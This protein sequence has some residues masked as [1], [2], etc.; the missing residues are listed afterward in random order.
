VISSR[1]FVQAHFK[2][3]KSKTMFIPTIANSIAHAVTEII[4]ESQERNML[5]NKMR[6]EIQRIRQ[7]RELSNDTHAKDMK[8]SRQ[9]LVEIQEKMEQVRSKECPVHRYASLLK[10][11]MIPNYILIL[12]AQV[13]RQVH[14][15]CVDVAQLRLAE[16]TLG[17][18]KKLSRKQQE[19]QLERV[20]WVIEA[21]V[22][23]L[24][25][26]VDINEEQ[27]K[28]EMKKKK[29]KSANESSPGIDHLVQNL[30]KLKEESPE[31]E[32]TFE[33]L[34]DDKNKTVNSLEQLL[35]E[36]MMK[37]LTAFHESWSTDNRDSMVSAAANRRNSEKA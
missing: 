1:S 22:E 10:N 33:D 14:Y 3:A 35:E 36:S 16:N 23:L 20:L 24:E 12:Q 32:I 2:K 5:K 17:I 30:S 11:E 4:N 9:R 28:L 19:K 8:H 34:K 6:K 7:E 25:Q 27:Q 13:C 18:L 31:E 21:K 37:S 26:Q 15:M 29:K